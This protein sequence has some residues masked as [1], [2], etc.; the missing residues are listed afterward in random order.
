M[1]KKNGKLKNNIQ[2]TSNDVFKAKFIQ[3]LQQ[4]LAGL[5]F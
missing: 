5:D 3:L 1:I 2:K 4:R